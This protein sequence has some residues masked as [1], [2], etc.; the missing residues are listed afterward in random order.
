MAYGVQ[1]GSCE[2]LDGSVAKAS[3]HHV[4]GT[5]DPAAAPGAAQ[6]LLGWELG[7][8]LH[9][10]THM[11]L[12]PSPGPPHHTLLLEWGRGLPRWAPPMGHPGTPTAGCDA[13]PPLWRCSL[14]L[15]SGTRCVRGL[16]LSPVVSYSSTRVPAHGLVT[17]TKH[18]PYSVLLFRVSNF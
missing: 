5:L 15:L 1:F 14:A 17:I 8:R 11:R 4:W 3:F 10:H 2:Y 6:A 7:A 9:A 16:P 18:K 12:S 13:R